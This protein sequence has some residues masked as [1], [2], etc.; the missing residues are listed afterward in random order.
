[1]IDHFALALGHGLLAVAMLRLFLHN[2]LDNDPLI[3][4]I[5]AETAGQRAASGTAGRAA[6]RRARTDTAASGAEP[7]EA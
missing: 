1:M 5:K 2:G 6:A 4:A 3:D 7:P